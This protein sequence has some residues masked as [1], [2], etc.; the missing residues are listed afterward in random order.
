MRPGP[1]WS[2]VLLAG[3][4]SAVEPPVLRVGLDPRSPPFAYVPGREDVPDDLEAP[5]QL[6]EAQLSRLVG[7]EIDVMNA[8]AQRIAMRPQVVQVSWD[9]LEKG[10]L[11][12]RYDIILAEWTP[13]PTTPPRILASSP[14]IDWSL[15]VVARAGDKRIR[16]TA[17]LEGRAVG[18]YPDPS[19]ER[20]LAAMRKSL[21]ARFMVKRNE[22]ILFAELKAGRLDA[23]IYDSMYVR[24]RV[25][26]DPSLRIVGEPLSR[27]GYHVGVRREDQALYDLIEV[28]L[29]EM[30]GGGEV[31]RLRQRWDKERP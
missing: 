6:S 12:K 31:E 7:F 24:W 1:L 26:R 27:L 22:Q 23:V 28:A 25:A 30:V 9:E 18:H 8:I 29:R 4:A 17:D 19:V 20:G 16:S 3:L 13:S 14:Y 11:E 21:G 2:L 10:L 15:V 5:P